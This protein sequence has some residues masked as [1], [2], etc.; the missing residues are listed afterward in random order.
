MDTTAPNLEPNI[1]KRLKENRIRKHFILQEA[2]SSDISHTLEAS[3]KE[4]QIRYKLC[5]ENLE[6]LLPYFEMMRQYFL[7][8]QSQEDYNSENQKGAK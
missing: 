2:K 6:T 1:I 4:S 7:Y 5:G 8:R 3:L